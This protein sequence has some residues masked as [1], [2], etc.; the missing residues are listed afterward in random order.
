MRLAAEIAAI[1][2]SLDREFIHHFW[3]KFKCGFWAT[4]RTGTAATG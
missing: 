2:S 4:R 1:A 3:V